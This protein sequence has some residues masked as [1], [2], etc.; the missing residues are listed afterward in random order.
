M[1]E[2]N[3]VE[4]KK[5][6]FGFRS[7]KIWKKIIAVLY[8][9]IGLL[10]VFAVLTDWTVD[11]SLKDT[12]L[13]KVSDFFTLLI[14]FSPFLVLSDFSK[15]IRSKVPL[16]KD[17]KK[18]KTFLFFVIL[19][20]VIPII[21][22]SITDTFHSEEY[23]EKVKIEQEEAEKASQEAQQIKD[24]EEKKKEEENTKKEKE[25][26]EK[27][28]QEEKEKK[29]AEEKAKKEKEEADKKAK[30]EQKKAEQEAKVNEEKAFKD[31]CKTYKYKEIA[32]NPDKYVGKNVKFTGEVMQVSEGWF[33][34]V[35]IL[36]QV[37]KNE[38][39]WYEDT[40]YCNYT[41]KDGEDKIL[42]D[43]IITI[44]GTCEGDTS[45]ISVLGSSIT[46][47]EVNIKYLK[48]K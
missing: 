9:F 37:T 14:Y 41:Y 6:I 29:E 46:I 45:Y 35:T 44:Y 13:V 40:V 27:K 34:S 26:A 16:L 25:E 17:N 43:D 21:S 5:R 36:L 30:E 15:E 38:Y 11:I 4:E 10:M 20:I 33:N 24:E 22:N 12:I 47:P 1:E 2:E 8:Y 48:I 7:Q 39:G 42:E 23:K 32:R 18:G 3:K 31:S 28:A 19:I